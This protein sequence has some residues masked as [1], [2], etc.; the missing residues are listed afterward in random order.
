MS[1][2]MVAWLGSIVVLLHLLINIAHAVAH[3]E[4]GIAIWQPEIAIPSFRCAASPA[5]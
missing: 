3:R 4:L 5:H 2:R 1:N